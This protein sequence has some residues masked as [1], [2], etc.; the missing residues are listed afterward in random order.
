MYIMLNIIILSLHRSQTKPSKQ[1]IV[2]LATFPYPDPSKVKG[3]P[4]FVSRLAELARLEA[5][6]IRSEQAKARLMSRP[7]SARS[8][9]SSASSTASSKSNYQSTRRTNV[10]SG[11]FPSTMKRMNSSPAMGGGYVSRG[12]TQSGSS[13]LK[14]QYSLS[15]IQNRTRKV[16]NN[17]GN[18]GSVE[19]H[20]SKPGPSLE[21][22]DDSK[23]KLGAT[24]NCTGDTAHEPEDDISSASRGTLSTAD[25][26]GDAGNGMEVHR[27]CSPPIIFV[28]VPKCTWSVGGE[29][30]TSV[31]SLPTATT[32]EETHVEQ[33]EAFRKTS[34]SLSVSHDTSKARVNSF[35]S[36]SSV[37]SSQDSASNVDNRASSCKA[38]V[39]DD[40]K[41]TSDLGLSI[42][43]LHLSQEESAEQTVAEV[44]VVT[45]GQSSNNTGPD[46]D[47]CAK[48][49]DESVATAN[50]FT[51]DAITV[52]PGYI[53]DNATEEVGGTSAE[54]NAVKRTRRKNGKRSAKHLN[55][56]VTAQVVVSA[57]STNNKQLRN[58]HKTVKRSSKK[59]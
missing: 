22:E 14:K 27:S 24:A 29:S 2:N 58:T 55:G 25:D 54:G 57:S 49:S 23:E 6:T 8:L 59:K 37:N 16:Y 11:R 17:N 53:V 38:V 47:A 5:V 40:L 21:R 33:S 46:V 20:A 51:T 48:S 13:V 18:L 34:D 3:N 39:E 19:E 32:N 52:A 44:A 31:E 9:K 1:L 41:V 7:T 12:G 45:K 4:G 50:E 30:S 28:R 15:D 43:S 56:S 42:D 35:S 36:S 26:Y 10:N